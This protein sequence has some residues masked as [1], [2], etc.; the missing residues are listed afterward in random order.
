M[1]TCVREE[2]NSAIGKMSKTVLGGLLQEIPKEYSEFELE[3]NSLIRK[4][5][6]HWGVKNLRD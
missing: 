3:L 1:L 5:F 2:Q 4:H 6:P